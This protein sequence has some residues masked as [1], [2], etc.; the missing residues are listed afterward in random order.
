VH[1]KKPNVSKVSISSLKHWRQLARRSYG[2]RD[3]TSA[4]SVA[5]VIGATGSKPSIIPAHVESGWGALRIWNDDEIAPLLAN[6][7]VN[8]SDR[9]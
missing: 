5:L 7:A 3:R 4:L 9:L 6:R 1:F 8:A 2:S